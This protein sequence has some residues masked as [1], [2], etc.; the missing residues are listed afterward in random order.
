MSGRP[1]NR[2]PGRCRPLHRTRPSPPRRLPRPS[3]SVH[4]A[5]RTKPMGRLLKP[6]FR[7]HAGPIALE[8]REA[9]GPKL[10][11]HAAVF[12]QWTEIYR[13]KY[14]VMREVIRPG[15]FGNAL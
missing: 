15:A 11:G 5:R 9:A 12:D 3:R 14:W 7:I 1:P 6:E 10:S 2:P 4:A 8:R 13:G